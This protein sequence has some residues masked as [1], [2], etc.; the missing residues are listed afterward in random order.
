VETVVDFLLLLLDH[1]LLLLNYHH[2]SWKG[3]GEDMSRLYVRHW[4]CRGTL[5]MLSLPLD[6]NI[7]MVHYADG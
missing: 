3:G 2:I 6:V 5:V 1:L 7:S 4:L